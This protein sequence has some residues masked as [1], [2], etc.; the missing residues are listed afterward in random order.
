MKRLALLATFACNVVIFAAPP[1]A[2][3]PSDSFGRSALHW[4]ALRGDAGECAELLAGGTDVAA[5]DANGETPLHLAARR[6]RTDVAARLIAAGADVRARNLS[7]LT[8]LALAARACPGEPEALARLGALAEILIAAGADPRD[9]QRPASPPLAPEDRAAYHTYAQV[10]ADLAAAEALHPGLCRRVNLGLTVQGRTM[11][12][13]CISDNVQLQEDEPEVAYISTMHGDE[14]IGMEMCLGLIDYL[15]SNYAADPRVQNL[16]NSLEIWIVPV[17]NPDGFVNGTRNNAHG[18]NLNRNFP[19]PYTSPV[20]TPA[21]REVE[22]ANIM[23]WRFGRSLTLSA[24]FHSGAMVV[25]Y[26]Y[27]AN[28]SGQSVYT[29][30]PDDDVFIWASEEYSRYNAPMWN[31]PTFYH[32]ITNGADWYVIYG[33]MQDWAYVYMGGNEVTIELADSTPPASQIVT[34]WNNNRESMM[35]Y[36]ETALTGV[37]GVV[38][39][40]LTGQPLAATVTVVGRGHTVY[41]DPDV[42]DYHRLLR[43]GDYDLRFEAA[44]CA[45]RVVEDIVVS[46]G[47]ATRLNLRLGPPTPP[48]DMNC[49]GATDILDINPFVLA[50]SAADQYALLFPDC[51][52]LL[53]DLNGDGLVDILD[54]NPFIAALAE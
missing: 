47:P 11:W 23:N 17:M 4:A 19:C 33:G 39:H 37:R 24:N 34:Y 12:A 29:A 50:L 26:P 13:L 9:A 44:G 52:I 18:V 8:P 42:G 3:P 48:G 51:D 10:E 41:T 38:T 36:L 2:A 45:P 49:D 7:G 46:S 54:I 16:V 6:L 30:S 1:V 5:A 40:R 22:T 35:A 31:S 43:P 21:G 32:G 28:A 15:T 53:G 25:N 27:D 20:N 14:I